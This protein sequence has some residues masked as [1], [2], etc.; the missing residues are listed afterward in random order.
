MMSLH[1]LAAGSGYDYLT[2][3]VAA[4]DATAKGH[5]SLADYYEQKGESPGRWLGSGLVGIEGL[6][7]GDQVTADQMHSLFAVGDHPLARQRLEALGIDATASDFRDAMKLGQRWGTYGGGEAFHDEVARRIGAWN[8]S[9]GRPD[10]A[11]VSQQLRYSIRTDVGRARF[12]EQMGR[13]P[14]N[15]RELTGFIA[16]DS[17]PS[18]QGVAGY[19]LTFSPVKSVSAL[20]ALADPATAERIQ[21]CHDRAVADALRFIEREV[22]YTR[23]GRNGVR[24]V[25]TTGLVAAAFTHRDSRAGDPDLH[26][27]VAVAN[28]VQAIDD[29]A[30]LAIDGRLL[31]K[32]NVAASECY[33]TALERHLTHELGVRFVDRPGGTPDRPVREIAGVDPA[34]LQRWSQRDRLIV[35]AQAELVGGFQREQGR[36]P[37]P[38]EQHALAQRATLETREAKHEPRSLAEQR[39]VWTA[40]A[41]QVLGRNGVPHMVAAALQPDR[42]ERRPVDDAWL[43]RVA[44]RVIR[45]WSAAG[46]RGRSGTCGP[47]LSGRFDARI[48]TCPRHRCSASSTWH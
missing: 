20:W 33:N 15:P 31:F 27:H 10:S 3:Q 41:E 34:L 5:T 43:D 2:R 37:T 22:L 1:K 35:E 30:W 8:R 9:N 21:R 48:G 23:R 32:A 42:V 24:Q 12:A 14:L 29:G 44:D 38:G 11:P 25:Q 28:K 36:T 17:R 45:W 7:A 13:L 39:R 47:R 26:T 4:Q 16:R 46:R 6:S 40:Q 19:D 18:R